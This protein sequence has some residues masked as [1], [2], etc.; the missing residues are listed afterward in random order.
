MAALRVPLASAR[1]NTAERL[2]RRLALRR[3]SAPPAH[4]AICGVPLITGITYIADPVVLGV[5]HQP[6]DH[7]PGRVLLGV[8]HRDASSLIFIRT[9]RGDPDHDPCSPLWAERLGQ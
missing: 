3:A 8:H 2:A 5:R 9:V 7:R 4:T 1:D 6:A